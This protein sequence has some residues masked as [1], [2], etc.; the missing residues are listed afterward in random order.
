MTAIRLPCLHGWHR[1]CRQCERIAARL[2]AEFERALLL[3]GY[4]DRGYTPQEWAR[5]T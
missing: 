4:K 5:H 2:Q 3:Q 1:R